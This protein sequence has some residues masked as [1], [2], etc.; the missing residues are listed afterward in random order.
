MA[1]QFDPEMRSWIM[2]QVKSKDTAPERLVRRVVHSMGHRFRL[3]RRDLPGN[4]D[5]V[6]PS[7]R[8]VIFVNGCFWHGHSCPRAKLPQSR[9]EYWEAKILKTIARDGQHTKCLRSLGWSALVIWECQLKDIDAL[10]RRI[11]RFL[12]ADKELP[13]R[14]NALDKKPKT[15][16]KSTAPL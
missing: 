15:P 11:V 8:K 2:R 14:P 6:F 16:R 12:P 10:R 3:H 9:R 13:D 1:D 4:P 5:I 7:R